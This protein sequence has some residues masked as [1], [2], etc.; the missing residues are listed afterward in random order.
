MSLKERG[1]LAASRVCKWN[2]SSVS[3][4]PTPV[5]EWWNKQ[6]GEDCCLAHLAEARIFDCHVKTQQDLYRCMDFETHEGRGLNFQKRFVIAF[7]HPTE[8]K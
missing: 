2:T 8:E 3:R 4:D 1:V 7:G 5:T 6:L